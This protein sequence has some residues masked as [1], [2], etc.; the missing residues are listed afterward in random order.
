[1]DAAPLLQTGE[2]KGD[3]RKKTDYSSLQALCPI[4]GPAYLPLTDISECHRQQH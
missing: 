1:M 2:E 3:Q 4:Y